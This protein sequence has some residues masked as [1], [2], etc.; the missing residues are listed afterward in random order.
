MLAG[1]PSHLLTAAKLS[2]NGKTR[3]RSG[4]GDPQEPVDGGAGRETN[5]N[6]RFSS[7]TKP[8]DLR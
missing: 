6:E 8:G 3:V 7:L 4:E 2:T 5:R 1:R